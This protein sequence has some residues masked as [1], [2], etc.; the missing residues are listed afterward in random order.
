MW[1]VFFYV[2]SINNIEN[3]KMNVH[4][5]IGFYDINELNNLYLFEEDKVLIPLIENYMQK[6]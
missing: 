2:G 6:H 5:N 3:I 1:N 4:Q